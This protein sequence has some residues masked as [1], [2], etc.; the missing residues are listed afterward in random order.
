MPSPAP[1]C[2]LRL[3]R[4]EARVWTEN[5]TVPRRGAVLRITPVSLWLPS[6]LITLHILMPQMASRYTYKKSTWSLFKEQSYALTRKY[7]LSILFFPP[8]LR[9]LGVSI[10]GI[11]WRTRFSWRCTGGKGE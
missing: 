1:D 7:W 5:P 4:P 2:D 10:E 9:I 6:G 3:P 8:E 11:Q